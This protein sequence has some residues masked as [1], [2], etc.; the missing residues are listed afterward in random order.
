VEPIG[1]RAVSRATVFI[2][3][4]WRQDIAVLNDVAKVLMGTISAAGLSIAGLILVITVAAAVDRQDRPTIQEV[5]S[6]L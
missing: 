4:I 1:T 3:R 2:S 6:P 5:T